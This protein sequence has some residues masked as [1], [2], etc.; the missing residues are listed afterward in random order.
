MDPQGVE[1]VAEAA[2]DAE[3]AFYVQEAWNLL[4]QQVQQ[5]NVENGE[6]NVDEMDD[7]LFNDCQPLFELFFQDSNDH[8]DHTYTEHHNNP[9]YADYSIQ[10]TRDEALHT[11]VV[12]VNLPEGHPDIGNDPNTIDAPNIH[13][14]I[15]CGHG[16]Q[17]GIFFLSEND[18]NPEDPSP[19]QLV[20]TYNMVCNEGF[21]LIE[22]FHQR[23]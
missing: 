13:G 8:P 19:A 2:L 9:L 16:N 4:N 6:N 15:R 11:Y 3:I 5:N 1:F 21:R 12:H 22:F 7:E 17:F 14:G 18:F 10:I 20:W 23:A